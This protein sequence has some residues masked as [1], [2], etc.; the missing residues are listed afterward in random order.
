MLTYT[1][2][3][4][5]TALV[6]PLPAVPVRQDELWRH[7]CFEAF[8]RH[9][10]GSA[11]REFNFAPSG[12]WAAYDFDGYRASMRPAPTPAP[13]IACHAEDG[14]LELTVR[15]PP[16]ALPAGTGLRLALSAVIEDRHG[17]RSYWALRHPAEK[18]D[19]HH[20]D[21]FALEID[22]A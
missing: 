19:F 21:G 8:V 15:L 22:P 1:F 14:V 12:A 16:N 18:P 5:I 11:Y 3:G 6:I 4:D 20:T 9:E 17:H 2:A 13:E 7:T 10:A